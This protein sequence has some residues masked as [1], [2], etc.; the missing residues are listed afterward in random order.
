MIQNKEDY[1]QSK[2]FELGGEI[3]PTCKEI[4][5]P[6]NPN[7]Y[8]SFL[9]IWTK[10]NEPRAGKFY[11]GSRKGDP[12]VDYVHSST[13]EQFLEDFSDPKSEFKFEVTEFGPY[14]YI[15]SKE[16]MLLNEKNSKKNN[17]SY[18]KSN[19]IKTFLLPVNSN[20]IDIISNDIIQKKQF[21]YNGK[22]YKPV[23]LNKND[24][25]DIKVIQVRFMESH[26]E[27]VSKLKTD[28]TDLYG[29]TTDHLLIVVLGCPKD[30]KELWILIGGN[31]SLKAIL[32][33]KLVQKVNVLFIPKEV[34]NNF[35]ELELETLAFN[36]NPRKKETVLEPSDDDIAGLIVKYR[37]QGYTNTSPEVIKI[38][39]KNFVN[40]KDRKKILQ[41]VSKILKNQNL[42]HNWI[43]YEDEKEKK[44]LENKIKKFHDPTNGTWAC[45]IKSSMP[46]NIYVTLRE[47]VNYNNN[48]KKEDQFISNLTIFL[49][50]PS[51]EDKEKWEMQ[52]CKEEKST[53]NYLLKDKITY[54]YEVMESIRIRKKIINKKNKKSISN[55]ANVAANGHTTL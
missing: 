7:N 17:M 11:D 52:L 25:K 24:L 3:P 38:F 10:L 51:P 13:D 15:V 37:K 16:T 36:L 30:P 14:E 27:H 55:S 32:G 31:H 44:K 21:T 23:V 54:Q 43:N 26:P 6:D 47:I 22:T 34:Y 45:L 9:Y 42:P 18:N 46:K 1:K 2:Y 39:E 29:N 19:G 40:S 53:L 28:I 50:H 8:D 20:I 35:N 4:F 49:V 33:C 41:K 48:K 5:I 12:L